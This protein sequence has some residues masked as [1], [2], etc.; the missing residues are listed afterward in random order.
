MT[1]LFIA[2]CTK[3]D[4]EFNFRLPENGKLLAKMIPK[5]HQEKIL[6][7]LSD[8]DIAAIVEQHSR[9]GM[10]H[11]DE[12]RKIKD[13]AGLCYSDKMIPAKSMQNLYDHN[14]EVL[15]ERGQVQRNESAVAATASIDTTM[16][17]NGAGEIKA[18]EVESVLLQDPADA[19]ASGGGINQTIRVDKDRGDKKAGRRGMF[20]SRS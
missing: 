7:D 18:V 6:G 16:K 19:L 11:V 9:Y 14:Q 2:N 17:A 15:E 10:V 1:Q 12:A 8:T 3:Q 20:R 13:F 5:G 4:H